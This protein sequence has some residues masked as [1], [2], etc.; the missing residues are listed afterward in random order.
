MLLSMTGQ[1][2]GKD[3][4]ARANQLERSTNKG[5]LLKEQARLS[6]PLSGTLESQSTVMPTQLLSTYLDLPPILRSA[7]CLTRDELAWKRFSPH[8]EHSISLNSY[9]NSHKAGVKVHPFVNIQLHTHDGTDTKQSR[10]PPSKPLRSD[11]VS[12]L[13]LGHGR[14]RS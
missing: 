4:P 14:Q 6:L 7:G 9:Q 3:M 12:Q 1:R 11:R 5:T 10:P 2:E 8:E 13:P